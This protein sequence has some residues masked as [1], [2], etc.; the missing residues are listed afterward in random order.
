[1]APT[2]AREARALPKSE[3]RQPASFAKRYGASGSGCPTK[4]DLPLKENASAGVGF[5][6]LTVE[7]PARKR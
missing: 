3:D 1:M 5:G 4:I 2:P 7:N 6:E